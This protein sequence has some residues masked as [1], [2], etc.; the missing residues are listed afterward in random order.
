MCPGPLPFCAPPEYCALYLSCAPLSCFPLLSRASCRPVPPIF[1]VHCFSAVSAAALNTAAV[2]L[3]CVLLPWV[4][5]SD[6]AAV[7][8]RVYIKRGHLRRT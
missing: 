5:A 3:S 6:V 2:L 8:G 1:S 7:G 4:A